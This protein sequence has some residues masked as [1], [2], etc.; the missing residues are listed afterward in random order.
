MIAAHIYR[1][2]THELRWRACLLTCLQND[3]VYRKNDRLKV[4]SNTFL[5]F[6][7][8][9]KRD[10]ITQ[11]IT[12]VEIGQTVAKVKLLIVACITALTPIIY[13]SVYSD[14]VATH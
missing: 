9:K 8:E 10:I 1:E 7:Q 12:R 2:W 6:K 13:N 14:L 11:E 3:R 4:Y 5:Y